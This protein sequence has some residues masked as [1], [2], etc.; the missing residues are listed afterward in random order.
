M[1]QTKEELKT[2]VKETIQEVLVSNPE[3][4]LHSEAAQDLLV[5]ELWIKYRDKVIFRQPHDV[6]QFCTEEQ[7]AEQQAAEDEQFF[8]QDITGEENYGID[9]NRNVF[10]LYPHHGLCSA[11]RRYPIGTQGQCCCCKMLY[12]KDVEIYNTMPPGSSSFSC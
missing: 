9:Q 1:I 4:N 6:E 2:L 11:S 8:Q 12:K 3:L 10:R 7:A 5:E